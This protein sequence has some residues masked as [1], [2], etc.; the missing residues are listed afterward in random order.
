LHRLNP[1]GCSPDATAMEE[2]N[3]IFEA[4]SSLLMS[5]ADRASLVIFVGWENVQMDAYAAFIGMLPF[6]GIQVALLSRRESYGD[7]FKF[8]TSSGTFDLDG[9]TSAR[10]GKFSVHAVY[11]KLESKA[12]SEKVKEWYPVDITMEKER[13]K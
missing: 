12:L 1:V 13:M 7:L 9:L 6:R 2:Y 3:T 5:K 8:T 11:G 4:A 10:M